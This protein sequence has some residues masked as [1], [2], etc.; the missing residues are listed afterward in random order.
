MPVYSTDIRHISNLTHLSLATTLVSVMNPEYFLVE[1][2][3][4]R[5]G[6]YLIYLL[7]QAFINKKHWSAPE[8]SFHVINTW[9]NV[10]LKLLHNF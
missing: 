2:S 3:K 1:L 7:Y 9:N 5:H 4:F 6:D 8:F 10:T